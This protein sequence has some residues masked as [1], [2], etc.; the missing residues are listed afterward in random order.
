MKRTDLTIVA[1]VAVLGLVAA[2]WFLVLSP[3]RQEAADLGD[4]VTQLEAAVAEQEQLAATAAEAESS[5]DE[6]YHRVVVL[7]KA[8]PEDADTPSLLVELQRIADLDNVE[9]KTI[10]LAEGS[11]AGAEAAQV[12]TPPPLTAPGE[13]SSESAAP[14]SSEATST[15]GT[16]T[17][18][19]T[20]DTS[21]TGTSTSTATESSTT[22]E[23]S[24]T[25][26]ATTS[27]APATEATAAT[28]PIGATVGPAGL[29]VMPYDLSFSGG[30]FEVADFL[31][32]VDELVEAGGSKAHVHGRL[33][34][35]DGFS[36]APVEDSADA[37]AGIGPDPT[38]DVTL[39]VT[40]YLTPAEQGLVAGA[41]PGAPAPTTPAPATATPASETTT[42]TTDTTTTSTTP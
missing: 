40:T 29:P 41:T 3:K 11:S 2:F 35:V 23:T 21:T 22:A 18:T 36:L 19:S 9:F 37:T 7:G 24:A 4:K 39:A 33:L 17:D 25:A 1:G 5:Y 34:T 15:D 27:V 6:N 14:T 38:L 32:D 8:V 12:A 31:A 42:A 10:T 13:S 30:F 26:P 28:Q 20:T 16:T